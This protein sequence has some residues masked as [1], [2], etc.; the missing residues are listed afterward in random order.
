MDKK[1]RVTRNLCEKCL[2]LTFGFIFSASSSLKLSDGKCHFYN[3][4]SLLCMKEPIIKK[5]HKK[6]CAKHIFQEVSFLQFFQLLST[7]D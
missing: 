4:A 3:S 2:L 6:S 7:C 5:I 1:R